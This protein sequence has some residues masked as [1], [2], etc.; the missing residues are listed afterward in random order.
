MKQQAMN[1]SAP[2]VL[3]A[4]ETVR[5]LVQD[6]SV[7]QPHKAHASDE[8]SNPIYLLAAITLGIPAL[9]LMALIGTNPGIQEGMLGTITM[10]LVLSAFIV[11]AIFE[12]KRLADQPSDA[13]HH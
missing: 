4:S 5:A 9:A 13:D 10:L 11:A 2:R 3:D 12:I 8:P 1:V 6:A 7:S